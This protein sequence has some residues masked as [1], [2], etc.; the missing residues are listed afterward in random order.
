M[1]ATKVQGSSSD[2]ARLL[3][4]QQAGKQVVGLAEI[5]GGIGERLVAVGHQFL[6]FRGALHRAEVRLW[7][8]GHCQGQ[9]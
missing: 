5:G 6:G 2:L 8:S 4:A 7:V 9:I 3:L 1:A